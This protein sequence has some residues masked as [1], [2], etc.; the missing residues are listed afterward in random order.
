MTQD[1]INSS[2]GEKENPE[3]SEQDMAIEQATKDIEE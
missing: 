2:Y 1:V 3:E